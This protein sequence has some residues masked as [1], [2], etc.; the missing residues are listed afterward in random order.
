MAR[1]PTAWSALARGEFLNGGR[2][3]EPVASP[4]RIKQIL[5]NM[6]RWR[7]LPHDLGPFYVT[8]N[9]PEFMLRV[10]EDGTP[11]HNSRVVVG[12]S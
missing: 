7:W 4:A 10:V 6:Q 11:I 2:H 5:V 9:I 12:K 1:C 8:V 3:E